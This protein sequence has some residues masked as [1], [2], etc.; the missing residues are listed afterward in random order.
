MAKTKKVLFFDNC[1]EFL[2][3]HLR[4][5]LF[6]SPK[7]VIAYTDA[8]SLF[9]RYTSEEKGLAFDDLYMSAMTVDFMLDFR[10]WLVESR[11]EKPQTANHRFGLVRS[12]IKYCS[13]Q[14]VSFLSLYL[15][16]SGIPPLRYDKPSEE[17]MTEEAMKAILRQP[18]NTR[19]GIRDLTFMVVLYETAARVSELVN[20]KVENLF[21]DDAFPHVII[22]GKGKKTRSIPLTG[23]AC[24]HV[25]HYMGV[26]H[27]KDSVDTPLVFYNI[28]K[29]VVGPLSLDCINTFLHKYADMARIG[30]PEVPE[31]V[32]SHLFRRSKATHLSDNGIG[33]P[34]ISRYLGHAEITT[35]MV[36]VK[37]NQQ[38]IQE[39]LTRVDQQAPPTQD[40][41]E[42]D[43]MRARLCGLR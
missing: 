19:K 41:E 24:E 38:K 33:L 35:T 11:K 22:R 21:L 32:H 8:L 2:T 34:I 4:D 42:Y 31:N 14:E 36:Y 13:S 23:P 15:R 30:C 18:P 6:R 27:R 9:R 3:T 25:R 16:L 28:T 39:A 40:P 29:G 43:K 7:T 37:P 10:V 1:Y 26:Y 17:A 12:Y 20:L 5:R